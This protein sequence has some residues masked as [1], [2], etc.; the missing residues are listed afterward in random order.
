MRRAHTQI[1]GP[2]GPSFNG[3]T[4]IA[5][6]MN[7]FQSLLGRATGDALCNVLGYYNASLPLLTTIAVLE[8]TPAGEVVLSTA[9]LAVMAMQYGCPWDPETPGP[10]GPTPTK[11]CKEY[12]VGG[13]PLYVY[14]DGSRLENSISGFYVEAGSLPPSQGS[15]FWDVF[16]QDVPDGPYRNVVRNLGL[17]EW[18][19]LEIIPA[20]GS[21]CRTQFPPA[22]PPKPDTHTYTDPE[23]GCTLNVDFLGFAQEPGD[24]VSP[25]F[26]V[27]PASQER[28]DGGVIGGCNFSPV[29]VYGGPGGPGG[30]GGS[31]GGGGPIIGPKPDPLPPDT[32]D[33]PW[34][35][36]W[37]DSI[38]KGAAA[39][40]TEEI[41]ENLLNPSYEAASY[42]L[43]AAC[44]R[45]E[46]GELEK[47]VYE[48]PK[49]SYQDRLMAWQ[50]A[51]AEMQ[52]ADVSWA[53]RTCSGKPADLFLHW[54]SITFES[55][56]YTETGNSRLVK[57]LRYRGSSPGDVI[58]L[59]EHWKD[60]EWDTGGV[61]VYH[62]GS[63]VGTPQVWAASVDEGKRVLRH[64]FGEAGIDPDQVGEW[65]TSSSDNPRY[66]VSRR[67]KLK[68]IDGCWMATA[69]SGP[70]GWPEAAI[71]SPDP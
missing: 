26:T 58:Q 41:I 68:T 7:S 33:K 8:P 25:I 3:H 61:V 44:D 65:G 71:C 30:G 60:F 15:S 37:V 5:R 31:G 27:E 45:D 38:V 70:S 51:L 64:A 39:G 17:K 62:S 42:E 56:D 14:P 21:V 54:R 40:L 49:Q 53:T 19:W 63:P 47:Y 52:Q 12:A 22:P 18:Q 46:N 28:T 24:L 34:W 16:V 11:G 67:V 43:I 35:K 69:R 36:D 20:N 59:R 50:F 23:T 10:Q 48:F 4:P 13:G 6:R 55:D 32:P 66:G 1:E 2:Y 29:I 9:G 57:R